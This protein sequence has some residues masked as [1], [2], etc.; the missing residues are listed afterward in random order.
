MSDLVIVRRADWGARAPK[1]AED[2]MALPVSNV[3]IHHSAGATPLSVLAEQSELRAEQNYHMDQNHWNDIGYSFSIGPSGRV[4]ECRA[5]MIGAHTEGHNSDGFGI[6]FQ[7]TFI[8][9]LP[10]PAAMT[11]CAQLI[12][13]LHRVGAIAQLVIHGHRDVFATKCPGDTLYAALPSLRDLV[14]AYDNSIGVIVPDTTTTAKPDY[15]VAGAPVSIAVTPSGKGY[16]ILCAD[17]GIITFGD[18]EFLGRVH[19]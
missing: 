16:Y 9:H 6:C 3:Y 10:T 13:Q 14:R 17:G 11:A 15:K 12:A 5:Q 4:Y 2:H 19:Q 18:A 1:V 8:D 7:G